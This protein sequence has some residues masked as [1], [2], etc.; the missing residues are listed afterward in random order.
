MEAMKVFL[1]AVMLMMVMASSAVQNVA[2]SEGPSPAPSPASDAS[3]F[4]PTL[5]ASV[6]ALAMALLF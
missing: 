3:L 5:F 6:A 2:A 4:P 1:V